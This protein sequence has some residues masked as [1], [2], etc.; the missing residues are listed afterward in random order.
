MRS[1]AIS[2]PSIARVFFAFLFACFFACLFGLAAC[3][4]APGLNEPSRDAGSDGAVASGLPPPYQLF[5]NLT[6]ISAD[7]NTITLRTA[8]L[9]DHKTPFYGKGSASYEAYNGTNPNFSTAINLMGRIS[10]PVLAAQDV[11]FRIPRNPKVAATHAATGLGP[12]GI[13]LNGVILFNQYNGMRALLDTLEINNMDQYNGHPTPAP[14]LQYH[15]HMEPLYLTKTRGGGALVG[16]LLDGFPVYG[17]VEGGK[18]LSSAMLDKY[19]G[20]EHATA[21]YPNG[22]YHY[23]CTDDAPWLNGEG[24]YGTPGTVTR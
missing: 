6:S 16:F 2:T 11:S 19:H 23:H 5:Y 8:D 15:Y 18:R 3:G 1:R 14:A 7:E 21:E 9:P 12:I 22:I 4:V 13:A 17:P 24:Y 20:H 10:D